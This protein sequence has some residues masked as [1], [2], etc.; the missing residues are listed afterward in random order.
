MIL[1][2]FSLINFMLFHKLPYKFYNVSKS[3][4]KLE[5]V[6]G[7]LLLIVLI[8]ALSLAN[9]SLASFYFSIVHFSIGFKTLLW[10]VNEVGMTFFFLWLTLE[11]KHE[12]YEG[13]LTS[14]RQALLPILAAVGGVIAPALVY[15]FFV[16]AHDPI[17]LRGWAIP[18]ATD[19]AL[20]LGLLALLGGRIPFELKIFLMA[21]AIID[22][23]IAIV[24]IA[25]FYTDALSYIYLALGLMAWSFMFL[26]FKK[27]G[28]SFYI[29]CGVLVWLAFLNS[30]IHATLAGV[31][32]ASA[33]PFK[34]P[35][36]KASPLI[37]L[38]KF[39]TPWI[40]FFI[41]P[42][43]IFMNGGIPFFNTEASFFSPLSLGITLGLSLG[44]PFGIFGVSYGLIRSGWT[45]LPPHTNY[46]HLLG[47]AILGGVGFTMSI[48]ISNLAFNETLLSLVSRLA[49][50]FGSL[51]SALIGLSM[52]F[53]I[54][55]KKS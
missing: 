37:Q 6:F 31:A 30:G 22:D 46:L 38:K 44:K 32:V 27:K 55:F 17:L 33:I 53:F 10:W 42:L 36:Y 1:W 14:F 20:A 2:W 39:L 50:L 16:Q 4:F 12:F 41:L 5:A 11:I 45:N 47:V 49:V 28:R 25:L 23:I 35:F 21:L 26:P 15:I 19:V 18:V 7:I 43:F 3:F 13:T 54:S 29:I 24:V 9:S 51:I 40:R 52:L 34:K 8:L 48:F